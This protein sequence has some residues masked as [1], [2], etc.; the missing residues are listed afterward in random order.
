MKIMGKIHSICLVA[1]ASLLTV[2]PVKAQDFSKI[3]LHFIYI[4][5]ET[6][7]P[8]NKLCQRLRTVRDDVIEVNDALIIYLSD[9]PFSPVSLTNL[10]DKS[11]RNRDSE[12]SY[13]NII[14]A[15]QDFNSH[16][17][18][19]RDD[20]KNIIKLFDEFNFVDESG[21]LRYN[22]VVIDFYVGASFWSL[23]NNEKIIAHLFTALEAAKF[24]KVKFS[25]NVYKP[26][27]E[28]LK[29]EEGK[30]FGDKNIDGINSK[31][32]IFEY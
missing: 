4:D 24:P 21:E 1:L 19:A 12:D 28:R 2:M 11:G 32:R 27:D 30:P 8:V 29:H 31:L 18:V 6:S 23:G 22:S 7:T 5:H 15:L 9:G 16:S 20:R 3:N 17:T 25:F 14:A 10:Q 26:K 13:T